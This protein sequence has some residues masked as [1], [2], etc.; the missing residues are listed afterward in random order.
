MRKR[1]KVFHV[2]ALTYTGTFD[3]IL[4][5]YFRG[6]PIHRAEDTGPYDLRKLLEK[7]G[8][9]LI[10]SRQEYLPTPSGFSTQ[11]A[12]SSLCFELEEKILVTIMAKEA[13]PFEA[14]LMRMNTQFQLR[15]RA[16]SAQLQRC[17]L[18]E[19]N[20]LLGSLILRARRSLL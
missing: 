5:R 17:Q 15:Q 8:D 6:E 16:R 9:K 19:K 2:E 7:Y 1:D 4:E 3:S 20:S 18:C 11:I 12:W 10:R 14:S 13:Q